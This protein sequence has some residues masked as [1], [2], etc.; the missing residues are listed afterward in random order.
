MKKWQQTNTEA[1][2]PHLY[3]VLLGLAATFLC[4]WSILHL[5]TQASLLS[6]IFA[7]TIAYLFTSLHLTDPKPKIVINHPTTTKKHSTTADADL[8]QPP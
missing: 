6:H 7:S 4:W 8:R 2:P 3:S 1:K 5:C